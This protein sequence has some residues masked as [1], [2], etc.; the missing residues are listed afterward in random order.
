MLI[1]LPGAGKSTLARR[2][3]VIHNPSTIV[4]SDEIRK[5]LYGDEAIQ[6]NPAQVF[7]QARSNL[8]AA[9]KA[10]RSVIYDATNI[11]QRFRRMAIR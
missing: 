4:S 6:G 3:A 9:L 2:L 5:H 10:G 7:R 11:N 8:L 1:G